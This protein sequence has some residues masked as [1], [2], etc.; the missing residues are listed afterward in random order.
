MNNIEK[1]DFPIIFLGLAEYV[2]PERLSFPIGS[3]DILQISKQ[4]KLVIYPFTVNYM[5][6]FLFHKKIFEPGAE[7]PE[8]IVY[9][10]NKNKYATASWKFSGP[11]KKKSVVFKEEMS[12]DL[13]L[14]RFDH[15]IL[16]YCKITD[17]IPTPGNY[18]IYGHYGNNEDIIGLVEFLYEKYPPLSPEIIKAIESD[19]YAAQF[20]KME[21]GCGKCKNKFKIYSSINRFSEL[22]KEGCIWQYDLPELLSCE[23]GQISYNMK[24]YKESLHGLLDRDM[25]EVSE[26][27]DFPRRY[28]YAGIKKI[29]RTFTEL[30]EKHHDEND[31]QK[32]I[33]TNKVLLARF[34]ARK[35]YIKPNVLG[36]FQTDF[37]I[38]NTE[39]QL[40][41]IELERPGM[42]LFKKDG[43]PTADLMHAYGQVRD[44]IREYEKYPAAVLECFQLRP[45]EVMAVKGAIIA[46]RSKNEQKQHMQRHLSGPPYTGVEFLTFDDLATSLLQISRDL[47]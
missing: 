34:H 33:E 42:K 29:V 39:K 18:Y 16:E 20:V 31:L 6:V 30:L 17:I 40:I 10:E 24:Y 21:L 5:W 44:W 15:W 11:L 26:K 32:F 27:R 43:H 8:I 23:C 46:G 45:D 13:F 38:F 22:E 7:Q 4:K 25:C 19:P 47:A 14:G 2:K 37:A 28:A 12:S 35:L 3:I 1:P 41:L 36:K 9:D